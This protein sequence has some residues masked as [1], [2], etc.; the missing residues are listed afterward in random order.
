MASARQDYEAFVRWIH[1]PATEASSEARRFANMA[2][3]RFDELA[4]TSRQ[5]NNRSA[6][7]AQIARQHLASTPHSLPEIQGATEAG[8]WPWRRLRSLTVGP[9]RGFRTP[10][11]FDLRKR[12]VLCYG[13]N[14]SGKT[15][16]CE[17]LEYALLGNV[18][19]A[20][21]KRITAQTYLVNVHA[22]RFDAPVLRAT[23][24]QNREINVVAHADTYRFCFVEKNRIDSFSRLAA[25]PT[26]QRAELIAT[27]FGMDRFN[28]F[29]GHFNESMDE[30]LVL[31]N[32]KQRELAGKR[33]ALAQDQ[34]A[35]DGEADS[36]RRLEEEE[37]A[38]AL[39]YSEGMSYAV[40]KQL[41]GTN[42]A[43]GRLHQLQNI[44]DIVPPQVIGITRNG[45]AGN[46][47]TAHG[48]KEQ[49]DAVEAQLLERQNQVSFREL[50]TAVLALQPTEGDHCPACDTPL[51]GDLRTARNPYDKAQAGLEQ[52]SEL[53]E[54]QAQGRTT[55]A[56]MATA[57]RALR[58]ELA[59]LAKFVAA[60]AERESPIG[61]HLL[62]L[63]LE[64]AGA[65]WGS[66]Y[67]ASVNPEAGIPA[68]ESFLELADRAQVQD[69]A[70]QLALE[71]RQ[72][73]IEE[74]DRLDQFRS[75]IQT[76]DLRRQQLL[77]H[78]AA[79]RR[80]IAVFDADNAPLI[81]EA[82]QERR[83]IE[84]DAPIRSAYTEFLGL[85]RR[86]RNQLP[87]TL[88]AG[89]NDLARDLYNEFNRNDHDSDKLSALHLPLT[90]DQKVEVSF[91]GNPQNRVDALRILSEGHVR[92]LGLAILLAKGLRIGT[93]L[94]VFDD[95]I[96]AIDHDHRGGIRET[97]FESDHFRN[98][99]F[100]V[101]CHSNEFIKDIQQHLPQH[102]RND[103]QF[104][105]FRPHDGG[106]HPRIGR[107]EPT[108][109]YVTRA[110]AAKNSLNE[111]EA[112]AF[113]R[114]ALEMLMEKAW[115]WLASH[116]QGLLT[117]QLGGVGADPF[118]RN[119]CEAIWARLAESTTFNHPT[120]E[121]LQV[122]L[123][124]I[125]G[126]PAQNLVW[127]YLNKGTHEEADRDDFDA[128]YVELVVA[129]LE[130]MDALEL[131]RNR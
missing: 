4:E 42:E 85:L 114:Q 86:Y 32:V 67:P 61:Q 73:N 112:L 127:Q 48:L 8:D 63:P 115:R 64:P 10:E 57:S 50:Y 62:G 96:N 44:L 28:D 39:R 49:L 87:G 118:L 75:A 103:F 29:V 91:R 117:V 111:R 113:S 19:E 36:L 68:L 82:D 90:G 31:S 30:K 88:M 76:Q 66:I 78:V 124:T 22:R 101:T 110:R 77:E 54:L 105:L 116:D 92:C 37:A 108:R 23:D 56:E 123:G 100:I 2:L 95:A 128:A 7:L 94:V 84:R 83:D 17:A 55:Q 121:S 34:A 125:L 51:A 41:I 102:S 122:A 45:L 20:D 70:S 5:R 14:G 3:A 16:L 89:L 106:N 126:I 107:D 104:Y 38:L 99:Q 59:G 9:F 52:L 15:S 131:R 46:F 80:R 74:R 98:V 130:A 43:P 69:R 26:A 18:E 119:L 25:R 120:K 79:A 72:R 6:Y 11:P 109:N 27:L 12:I 13:P 21:L 47:A 129:T 93:P 53:G 65:W 60:N 71:D 81:A 24:A 58:N 33:N 35:V 40:V 97:L 1:E